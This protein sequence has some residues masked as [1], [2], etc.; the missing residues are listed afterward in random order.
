MLDDYFWTPFDDGMY[1]DAVNALLYQLLSW[2]DGEYG[3][4]VLASGDGYFESNG[5]ADG[6]SVQEPG[7]PSVD[8]GND[9]YESGHSV[10]GMFY[11]V[12]IIILIVAVCSSIFGAGRRRRYYSN[13]RAGAFFPFW[14]GFGRRYRGP[15]VRPPFDDMH[16]RP[17]GPH[18]RHDHHDDHW[19]GFG[20]GHG[21]GG[22]GGFGGG[23][24]H[25]GG[26]F[27]GGGGGGRR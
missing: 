21:G 15:D 13:Y 8:H 10:S 7:V 25:G 5:Y 12:F 27:S 23:S 14:F 6:D 19:G 22:F 24:G 16:R 17:G 11:S 18:D 3:S 20:G 2:Y 26:G 1:D 9:R 4:N